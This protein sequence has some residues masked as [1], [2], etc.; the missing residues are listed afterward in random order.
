MKVEKLLTNAIAEF[1]KKNP[2]AEFRG[3]CLAGGSGRF[4][5]WSYATFHFEYVNE[6]EGDYNDIYITVSAE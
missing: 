4:G 2:K 6:E 5:N 1:K 3:C